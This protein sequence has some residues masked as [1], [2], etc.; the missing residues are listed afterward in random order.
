MDPDKLLEDLLTEATLRIN[1]CSCGSDEEF[2]QKI[3][4][5]DE[6]LNK[7]GFLP[8]RWMLKRRVNMDPTEGKRRVLIAA[9]NF[10]P[11]QNRTEAEVRW[12]EVWTTAEFSAE[13]EV[14]SFLAPYVYVTRRSDGVK[15]TLM[16]Q[17]MPRFYFG[18]AVA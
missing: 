6:W 18:W 16:F 8:S 5:L 11:A 17:H 14:H 7:G 15:G 1:G 13:F 12:G 4:D 9:V 3:L 2:A 10:E